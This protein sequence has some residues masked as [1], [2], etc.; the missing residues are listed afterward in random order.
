MKRKYLKSI[1]EIMRNLTCE[2]VTQIA[3]ESGFSS[4]QAMDNFLR[5]RGYRILHTFQLVPLDRG[6]VVMPKNKKLRGVN[7]GVGEVS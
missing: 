3:I 5:R 2:T 1:N 7:K 6:V 4:R